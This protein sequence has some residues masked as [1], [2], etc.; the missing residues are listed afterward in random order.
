MPITSVVCGSEVHNIVLQM[1]MSPLNMFTLEG[2][3][4]RKRMRGEAE[5][6]L[7]GVFVCRDGRKKINVRCIRYNINGEA[8]AFIIAIRDIRKGERLYYDYNGM[9][10][11]YPTDHFE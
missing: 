6:Y 5:R 2:E 8:R 7:F 9:L 11:N 10:N 3:T 1:G 4:C